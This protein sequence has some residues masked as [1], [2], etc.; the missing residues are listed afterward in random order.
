MRA[1]A[2]K[3]HLISFSEAAVATDCSLETANTYV[4]RSLVSGVQYRSEYIQTPR[5][6]FPPDHGAATEQCF[7]NTVNQRIM[8]AFSTEITKCTFIE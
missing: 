8:I 5:G 7:N 1:H 2:V 6:A 3:W 4:T